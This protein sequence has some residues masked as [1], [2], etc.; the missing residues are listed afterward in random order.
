MSLL[1]VTDRDG[2]VPQEETNRQSTAHSNKAKY[3]RVVRGDI[4]YNTMRM[5]EGRSARVGTEG[6]VSPAYTVC[7][8]DVG[9]NSLF[10][11]YYFKTRPLIAE[12]R[13][14]S[15]GLVKDTL[16]LKYEAFS[17][18]QVGLPPPEEQKKI[19][20]CLGSLD[21]VIAAEDRKLQA[22]RQHKQG[23]MQQL[24]PQPGETV[25]RLRFSDFQEAEAWKE[26]KLD[27]LAR[28]GTG[29]TPNKAAADYYNGG[30]KWVSLA[31]SKRLDNG[32]ISETEIEISEAGINNSSAV[33]H[34]SGSVILSRDAGVGKSAIMSGPMA[35]SQHFIVWTCEP[36]VMSNWFLYYQ[37]Q[38]LKPLFEQV[39]TGSTIK[40]IGLPF[41]K[42]MRVVVPRP[43]EQHR[44]ANCLAM[45]DGRIAAQVDRLNVLKTH[46]RG[47][48]QQLFPPLESQ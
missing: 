13:K 23:L 21:D 1:S 40:T 6:V 3:L 28:P 17:L 41:F 5:W 20:D 32:L 15:Q 31:D 27:D 48:L 38:R 7:R 9:T 42:S 22:L 18:I 14:Y 12:F 43:A 25:P 34:P 4:V 30:I 33:L 19:A 2:V 10:F 16:N 46:K 29:H 35:V 44:I 11:A 26:E 24:F 47:L 36:E 39:A 37:L 45:L 8:P